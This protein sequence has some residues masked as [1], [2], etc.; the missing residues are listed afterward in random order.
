MVVWLLL[1]LLGEGAGASPLTLGN[2]FLT[3]TVTPEGTFA[4]LDKR[5]KV[6]WQSASPLA[7]FRELRRNGDRLSF[8]TEALQTDKRTSPVRVTM[9]LE[10]DEVVVEADTDDRTRKIASFTVLPPLLPHRSECEI[11]LPFYGNGIA[12]PVDGTDFRGWWFRTY[13]ALGR[14]DRRESWLLAFVGWTQRE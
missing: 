1:A 2:Q 7:P 12:I 10:G 4:V 13:G 9:W 5:A 14:L 6:T 3:V 8:V 11:L